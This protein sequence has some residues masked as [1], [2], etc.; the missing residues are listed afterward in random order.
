[1][2]PIVILTVGSME[3]VGLTQSKTLFAWSLCVFPM[4]A[5][6]CS[7]N[8]KMLVVGMMVVIACKHMNTH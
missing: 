4:Y 6:V 8:L 3:E 5:L 7:N 1:M 2:L